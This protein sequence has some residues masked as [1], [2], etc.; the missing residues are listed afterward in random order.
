MRNCAGRGRS[1][2]ERLDF[3]HASRK[4]RTAA[5]KRVEETLDEMPTKKINVV[6]KNV[7]ELICLGKGE[8]TVDSAVEESVCP[9]DWGE[10][11]RI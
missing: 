8:I 1:K 10:A 5:K 2:S 4:K 9:K 7:D 3:F 11:Y 6:T